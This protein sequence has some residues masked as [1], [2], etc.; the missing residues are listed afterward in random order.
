MVLKTINPTAV[1]VHKLVQNSA[2]RS[3]A[4]ATEHPS[5]SYA[6][7]E[8]YVELQREVAQLRATLEQTKK[9][10]DKRFRDL[11]A[12]I[13]EEKKVRLNLQV[14]VERLKKMVIGQ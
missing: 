7:Q 13:D 12:E 11:V 8:Q 2:V 3:F 5:A 14:E 4:E 1:A 9:S 6:T 10:Q